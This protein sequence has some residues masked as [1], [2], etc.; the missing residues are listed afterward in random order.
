[1]KATL[2]A[3]PAPV[4][5]GIYKRGEVTY[6]AIDAVNFSTLK[7]L[8]RS[9]KHYRHVVDAGGIDPTAPMR[10]GTAAHVATLEPGRFA[11]EYAAVPDEGGKAPRR[12]TKAWEAFAAAND[13]RELLKQGEYDAAVAMRDAVRADALA[14]RYLIRGE[15]EVTLVWHDRETGILCKG[16]IDWLSTSVADIVVELKTAADVSPSKFQAAYARMLYHGQAAFYTDAL[17]TLTGRPA[18]H[19]CVAVE[20]K[21][22]HDVVVY[23]V[24][25]E[26]LEAGT[27]L[28]RDLL[29]QL[30]ECRER[31]EWCGHGKGAE[32]T[33]RLPAW[34]VAN[35]DDLSDLGLTFD[36]SE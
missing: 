4:A 27:E 15:P 24:I 30:A 33:L 9:A 36:E 16:R 18:Y 1:M 29:K 31:D 22:P 2:A 11:R 10:L 25:G 35:D 20:S 21:A 6:D 32:V 12:G 8:A 7:H 19:K 13:G 28:Y 17:E 5:P 34:A 26:P 23:D 3:L 14:M